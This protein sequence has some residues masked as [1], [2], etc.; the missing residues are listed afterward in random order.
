VASNDGKDIV[1]IV[2]AVGSTKNNILRDQG[3]ATEML[4]FIGLQ[5]YH[6][7]K[8]SYGSLH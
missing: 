3:T 2:E 8:S 1:I 7:R 4:S 5:G 6:V